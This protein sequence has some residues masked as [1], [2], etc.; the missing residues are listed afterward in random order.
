[1]SRADTAAYL[2]H[3]LG[4]AGGRPD[5]FA[6]EACTAIHWFGHGIPRLTNAL[7]DLALVYAYADDRPRV[8]LDTV[9]EA[10]MDRARGGLTGFRRPEG[11]PSLPELRRMVLGEGEVAE[12]IAAQ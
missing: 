7:A 9:L 3:R 12:W 11:Q 2:R 5:L 8:D 1:M 4:I 10:A 6:D